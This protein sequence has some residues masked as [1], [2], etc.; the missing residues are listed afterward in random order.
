M[1]MCNKGCNFVIQVSVEWY[2]CAH[3][4]YTCTIVCLDNI[5]MYMYI[6]MRH[7][8]KECGLWYMCLTKNHISLN[9]SQSDYCLFWLY[10]EALDRQAFI[11]QEMMH[12]LDTVD[13]Q[14]SL[15][16]QYAHMPQDTFQYGGMHMFCIILY[17]WIPI[18]F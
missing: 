11:M 14:A 16:C 5:Y 3:K 18:G 15:N 17:L 9:I 1:S 4:S 2:V 13:K 7:L 12:C 8:L 10:E 6:Y